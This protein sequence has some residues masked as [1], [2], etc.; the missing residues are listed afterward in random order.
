[1]SGPQSV[2]ATFLP[3]I[4]SDVTAGLQITRGGFRFDR[5]TNRFVQQVD[6]TNGTGSPLSGVVLAIDGAYVR[7]LTGKWKWSNR[8]R[9]ARRQRLY[10]CRFHGC[11]RYGDVLHAVQ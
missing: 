3:F 5:A 1:M 10:K 4:A 9:R 6:M 7:S 11:R 2:T 8:M